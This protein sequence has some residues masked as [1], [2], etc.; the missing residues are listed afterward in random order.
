MQ[1]ELCKLLRYESDGYHLME[2]IADVEIIL[3]QLKLIF[4]DHSD[5]DFWINQKLQRAKERYLD[6]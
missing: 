5:I 2:E 6:E 3:E 1:K 4:K